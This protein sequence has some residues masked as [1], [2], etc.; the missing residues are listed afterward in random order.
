MTSEEKEKNENFFRNI[1]ILVFKP[2]LLLK[3]IKA[4][5]T[6]GPGERTQG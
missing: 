3:T 4:V 1:F 5:I 2:R 6:Q